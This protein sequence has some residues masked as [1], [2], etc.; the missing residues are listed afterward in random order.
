MQGACEA[1]S[2]EGHESGSCKFSESFSGEEFEGKK[3]E[4]STEPVAG[5]FIVRFHDYKHAAE[6]E[7]SLMSSLDGTED[8]KCL[9]R[10]NAA[11]K[12]PTDFLVVELETQANTN[13]KV[14][15]FD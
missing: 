15:P 7:A 13:L 8:L 14:R 10:Q 6:H 12:Y 2:H 5:Q 3:W 11:A 9:P 1:G 4:Y